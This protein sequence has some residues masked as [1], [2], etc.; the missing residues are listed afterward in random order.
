[1]VPCHDAKVMT[2]PPTINSYWIDS[3]KELAQCRKEHVECRIDGKQERLRSIETS[4]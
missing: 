2:P 1:M 4:K 3:V